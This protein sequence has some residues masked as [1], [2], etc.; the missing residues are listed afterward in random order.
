MRNC[1]VA[2]V[3]SLAAAFLATAQAPP[4]VP[5]E[6]ARQTQAPSL[7]IDRDIEYARP[8]GR[9]LKL[10]LY[11]RLPAAAPSPVVVWLNSGEW[12]PGSRYPTPAAALTTYGYSVASIDYRPGSE[13]PFPAQINDAKAAIRWL[14]ANAAKYNLDPAHI[15]VWGFGGGGH[16]AALLGTSGDVKEL[17]GDLGNPDQSSRVQAVV[18]F[19]GPIDLLRMDKL[20]TQPRSTAANAPEAVWLG[21]PLPQNAAKAKAANPVTY[22]SKDDAPFLIVHGTADAEIPT[23]QSQILVSA[24]KVAG[25]DAS[26]ELQVGIGHEIGPL[27]NQPVLEMV[28][29]FFY[30]RLRGQRQEA[31]LSSFLATPSDSYVDPIALDLAGTLYKTY[32]TPS[33]GPNTVASYRLYLPPDYESSKTRRYPVIYFLHGMSVDSKRPLT[34]GYVARIDADI[35]AGIMPPVIVVIP[36]GLNAGW[37]VDSKDGKY[38]TE[39]IIVKDLISHVD[40]A[41]RTIARRE[42]RAIEGHS[43]GG[44]GALRIG[45]SHPELFCAVTGNS[46]AMVP[47]ESVNNGRNGADAPAVVTFGNDPAY[48]DA[49][50]P[51]TIA[52]KNPEK[53]RTQKIRLIVGDKDNLI[54]RSV[55]LDETL[56]KLNVPHEFTPVPGSPHNHDQLLA[57]MTW[58]PFEFYGKLF[59]GVTK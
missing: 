48:F 33:R 37:W 56:K 39:S 14:R 54:V 29:G 59:A 30:Q 12:S 58:D 10:D 43:M 50:S 13:A 26:L 16:L 52:E 6:G 40:G 42:A 55:A 44:Y 5:N 17:E 4:N 35:R 1:F 11:R 25:I 28:T 34:A 31:Q 53:L 22:I 27:L 2:P 23:R 49:A 51:F 41:Y 38:P 57:F 3:L 36:Q 21:G 15:G 45:F 24:L 19:S 46:A 47:F 32:A 8:G 9:S 20:G 7:Q 18:D